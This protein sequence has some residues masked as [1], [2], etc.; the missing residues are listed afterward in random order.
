[1]TLLLENIVPSR[2]YRLAV[3]GT[4]LCQHNDFGTTSFK[5]ISH[6]S[7][8]WMSWARFYAQGLFES[9]VW[10]DDTVYP[11][12]EPTGAGT[13]RYFQG[14]NAG[15][16]NTTAAEIW[17]RREYLVKNIDCDIIVV[18]DG[19]ND[20]TTLT[21]EQVQQAREDL[22]DYYLSYNKIII[23]LPILAR[24]TTVWPGGGATRAKMNWVNAKTREFCRK[25]KNC[26][27]FD[28]NEAWVDT[29]S[30]YG[31]PVS[32][33]SA[34]GT[35][36]V[37]K[38]GEAVGKAFADFLKTILPAGQK[39]V[40]SPDDKYSATDNPFGNVLPNPFLNGTGGTNGTGSSGTVAA[41]M[42]VER[43]SGASTV[44][45]SQ[46][47][48]PGRGN[49]QVMT[50]TL[51]GAA[52]DKFYFRPST[53]DTPHTFTDTDWVQGSCEVDLNNYAGYVGVSLLCLDLQAGGHYSYGMEVYNN[54][55]T[56]E[57]WLAQARTG[58]ILTP[59]F[60][61]ATGSTALK[62]RLEIVLAASVAGSPIVKAGAVELRK[63]EDPRAAL[64][65]SAPAAS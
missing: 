62:W 52:E 2:G 60:K 34:D 8:G 6:S 16:F 5:K 37:P 26:F 35:H 48:R 41:N 57:R 42:L 56:N 25:R 55:S 32:G 27:Y 49:W 18:D 24:N 22:V 23:F 33:H 50:F 47:A 40:T 53:T 21:K 45:C 39:R 54:G 64:R 1:M 31:T 10:W 4:S 44:V 30:T 17:A 9:T 7:R 15:V 19:T 65:W 51:S 38:G 63:V 14:L 3:I 29:T 59:P 46:E 13:T 11:G 20:A 58:H 28:W 61:I 36:F 43:T 12:W